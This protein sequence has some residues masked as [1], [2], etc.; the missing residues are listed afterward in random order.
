MN[1]Y[2]GASVAVM[3]NSKGSTVA[4]FLADFFFSSCGSK[5]WCGDFRLFVFQDS[6]RSRSLPRSIVASP[7]LVYSA[8][9]GLVPKGNLSQRKA[10]SST[11][12][13]AC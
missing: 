3:S 12:T 9:A 4:R 7:T 13:N 10:I 6:N 2:I 1:Q 11:I 5:Y 8:G